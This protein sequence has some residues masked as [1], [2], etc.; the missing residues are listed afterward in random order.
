MNEMSIIILMIFSCFMMN[1]VLQCALGVSGF[2][3]SKSHSKKSIIIKL[4]VVF[5]TVILLWVIFSVL[6]SA[7]VSG[8]FIYVLVFPAGYM[9]YE[10]LDFI[11]FRHILKRETREESAVGFPEGITSVI[12]FICIYLADNFIKVL[13]LALGFTGGALM[14]YLILG[15]IQKRASLETVPV[16]LRGKPLFLISMGM[17]SLVFSTASVLIFRVIGD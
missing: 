10:G 9:V 7:V 4:S 5:I 12:L 17:L 16:F 13:V 15:E 11:V 14:V 3:A 2:T 6:I 1:P 8:I